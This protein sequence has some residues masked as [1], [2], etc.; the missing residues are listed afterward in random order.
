M[1]PTYSVT[2]SVKRR[3]RHHGDLTQQ[4]LADMVGVSRQ[5]IVSIEKGKYNPTVGLALSLA[6]ALGVTVEQLF[7]LDPGEMP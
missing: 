4:Q 5:T 7:Q 2:N 6:R 3:R 1:K